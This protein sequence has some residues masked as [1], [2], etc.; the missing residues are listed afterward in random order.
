MIGL[1]QFVPY[2]KVSNL[3]NKLLKLEENG[4]KVGKIEEKH[5]G[6]QAKILDPENNEYYIYEE[7]RG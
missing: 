5:W 4:V 2:F 7:I 6:K 1:L 3:K